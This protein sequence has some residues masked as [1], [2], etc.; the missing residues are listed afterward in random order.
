MM[1]APSKNRL[2][3][4]WTRLVLA[5]QLVYKEESV[6][7]LLLTLIRAITLS[8][9]GIATLAMGA[10]AQTFTTLHTFIND[11]H[12]GIL[13]YTGLV[14][15]NEGNLYGVTLGGGPDGDGV[16]FKIATATTGV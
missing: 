8:L 11:G 12:D 2:S 13:P 1:G 7:F 5:A 3:H 16:V 9:A 15:D 4:V 10:H 6:K 14:G